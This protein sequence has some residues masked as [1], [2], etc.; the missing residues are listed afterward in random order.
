MRI[1][2]RR[3]D[4][5]VDRRGSGRLALREVANQFQKRSPLHFSVAPEVRKVRPMFPVDDLRLG[6]L[7]IGLP[8]AK[9]CDASHRRPLLLLRTTSL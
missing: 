9:A 5:F 3:N 6:T 8:V 4:I 1:A 2:Y 7:G